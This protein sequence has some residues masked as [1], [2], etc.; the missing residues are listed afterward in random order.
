MKAVQKSVD[1]PISSVY[2]KRLNR[3]G[4]WLKPGGVVTHCLGEQMEYV[5]NRPGFWENSSLLLLDSLRQEFVLGDMPKLLWQRLEEAFGE[6]VYSKVLHCLT[7]IHFEPSVARRHWEAIVNHRDR[8][9]DALGRDPG[10]RVSMADYFVNVHP[11]VDNPMIVEISFFLKQEERT[12]KDEL[13]GL[14]NRRFFNRALQQEVERARRYQENLSLLMIDV[15]LFKEFNDTH[16]HPAGDE[17]LRELAG[18]FIRCSRGIDHLVRYGGEEFASILPRTDREEA[19]IVAERLRW[20]VSQNGFLKKQYLPLTVSIGVAT[21]PRDAPDGDKLLVAADRALY[22]A[23]RRGRNR[24]ASLDH[25][26]HARH[27]ARL[28]MFFHH[29][30][31][32]ILTYGLTWN[33]SQGGLL[34][35]SRTFVAP[36]QRLGVT[37]SSP[38]GRSDFSVH[39]TIL[40]VMPSPESAD[41]YMLGI[42]FEPT[43]ELSP[44]QLS[45]LLG[46]DPATLH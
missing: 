40:R 26:A 20:A 14:Y 42:R 2:V 6:E 37:I 33:I 36:G 17:A 5:Y 24:V 30:D 34:G 43:A 19:V 45:L 1:S 13:T 28:S 41:I 3:C 9:R 35:E 29:P 46:Q 32:Q 27:P 4:T 38:D 7:Q 18:L 25:R 16:G 8:L 39:G 31:E 21:F 23:K 10:L 22:T 12:L 11:T 44:D 15:D